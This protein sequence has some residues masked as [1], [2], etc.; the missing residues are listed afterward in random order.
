MVGAGSWRTELGRR[1][2]PSPGRPLPHML[3]LEPKRRLQSDVGQMHIHPFMGEE[4]LLG[5]EGLVFLASL[6]KEMS[7]GPCWL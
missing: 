1:L 7:L 3:L 2:W 6:Y 4:F 5:A